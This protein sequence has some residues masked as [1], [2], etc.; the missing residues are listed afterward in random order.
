M[1]DE[2]FSPFGPHISSHPDEYVD[3]F[4]NPSSPLF[5]KKQETLRKLEQ[6]WQRLDAWLDAHPEQKS[7][8]NS[9]T[10]LQREH[11]Q[12]LDKGV[13]T[14][15]EGAIYGAC[16]DLR[17]VEAYAVEAGYQPEDDPNLP[18]AA[19]EQMAVQP[20]TEAGR[21]ADEKLKG[22]FLDPLTSPKTNLSWCQR[23]SFPEAVCDEKGLQDWFVWAL[24]G[25]AV[26]AV[27]AVGYAAYKAG[28]AVV[29]V[30]APWALPLMP[31]K[32]T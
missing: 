19:P 7:R 29:G 32:E 20:L 13:V 6:R 25:F 12:T 22:T 9:A 24:G 14:G 18:C 8:V 3:L 11:W 28:P 5:G 16:L 17:T 26:A 15:D 1:S 23:L 30:Y 10:R 4:K 2:P 27:A 31:S 21:L